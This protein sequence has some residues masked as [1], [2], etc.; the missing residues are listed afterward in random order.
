M[1]T[2]ADGRNRSVDPPGGP[3]QVGRPS[4]KSGTGRDTFRVF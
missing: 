2:F 3:E 1:D 4:R